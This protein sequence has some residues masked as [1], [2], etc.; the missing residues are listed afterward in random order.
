MEL[1]EALLK[2]KKHS[3]NKEIEKQTEE[4][5][6]YNEFIFLK[7]RIL[8]F[9]DKLAELHEILNA[10]SENR[11]ENGKFFTDGIDH[12]IGFYGTLVIRRGMY[13]WDKENT[14]APNGLFGVEGG[15][16]D[17][18][19]LV[20]DIFNKTL[21]YTYTGKELD[22]NCISKMKK[23]VKEFDSFYKSVYEYVNNLN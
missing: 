9:C 1:N 7:N 13:R 21:K 22:Y 5:K 15:G 10:L 2:I 4:E 3:I 23:I 16:C 20:V 17:G 6:K 8:S 11:I 18:G 12:G 14:I 19:D